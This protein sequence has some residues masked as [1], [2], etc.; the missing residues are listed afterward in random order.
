VFAG[1]YIADSVIIMRSRHDANSS[2]VALI[3]SGSEFKV[4]K[5]N[6]VWAHV[7][8]GKYSGYVLYSD[9]SAKPIYGDVNVDGVV[10]NADVLTLKK[11]LFNRIRFSEE[12]IERA[13]INHDGLVN[14]EDL[15]SLKHMLIAN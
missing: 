8:Y 3:A 14:V 2:I 12:R 15:L 13:D 5:T 7:T 1:D 4:T 11:Y 9:I 10:N 6:G